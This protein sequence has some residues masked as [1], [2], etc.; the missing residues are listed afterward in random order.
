MRKSTAA[1]QKNRLPPIKKK[2]DCRRPLADGSYGT[3]K[4]DQNFTGSV[5]TPSNR[6]YDTKPEKLT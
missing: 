1:D 4:T 2:I 3:S 6:D 5:Q